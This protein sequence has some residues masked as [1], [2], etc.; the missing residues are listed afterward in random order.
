MHGGGKDAG[1]SDADEA[2]AGA[3]LEDARAGQGSKGREGEG[4]EAPRKEVGGCPC[5]ETEVIGCEG[6]L[7]E[8][9]S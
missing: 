3:E 4:G 6:G 7:V 9:N 5:L 1:G 8:G 2:C